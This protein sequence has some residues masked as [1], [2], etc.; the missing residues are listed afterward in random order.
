MTDARPGLC[1][2][3]VYT[4]IFDRKTYQPL[5]MN[6]TGV[7]GFMKGLHNGEVLLKSAIVNHTPP[8]P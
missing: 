2:N 8:L 1:P 6:W 5:G 3:G 4:I 7:I